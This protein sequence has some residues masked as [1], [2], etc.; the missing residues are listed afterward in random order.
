M[1]TYLNISKGTMNKQYK[2]QTGNNKPASYINVNSGQL[3]LTTKTGTGLNINIKLP[4][5]NN[6]YI[7]ANTYKTTSFTSSSTTITLNGEYTI[8]GDDFFDCEID[9]NTLNAVY[10][11]NNYIYFKDTFL[12]SQFREVSPSDGR[13]IALKYTKSNSLGL[14]LTT[15]AQTQAGSMTRSEGIAT[16]HINYTALSMD[17]G[18]IVVA[19]FAL[20]TQEMENATITEHVFFS[21]Q[22]RNHYQDNSITM[23]YSFFQNY[24]PDISQMYQNTRRHTLPVTEE[25]IQVGEYHKAYNKVGSLPVYE[26][27]S[28]SKTQTIETTTM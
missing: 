27:G 10:Y 20:P 23:E 13:P 6:N 15:G 12:D 8:A 25:D 22:N 4:N 5:D 19:N 11:N 7:I 1:A 26:T 14:R 24:M 2:I 28:I 21:I 9:A 16:T 17:G 3:P 18:P